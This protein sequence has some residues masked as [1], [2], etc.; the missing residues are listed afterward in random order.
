MIHATHDKSK[1]E[2]A[3]KITVLIAVI[4]MIVS[5]C[6][7]SQGP[8]S[9][10]IPTATPTVFMPTIIA[11]MTPTPDIGD[12]AGAFA[13]CEAWVKSALDN[14]DTA[15]VQEAQTLYDKGYIPPR[16]VSAGEVIYQ[17]DSG[18]EEYGPQ[19]DC[20][21]E[22]V[23]NGQYLPWDIS[24]G[25]ISIYHRSPVETATPTARVIAPTATHKPT[26][27]RDIE[28]EIIHGA[29]DNCHLYT[30][31]Y[32]QKMGAV[33]PVEYPSEFTSVRNVE[34]DGLNV[35]DVAVYEDSSGTELSKSWSCTV[36]YQINSTGIA[37]TLDNLVI[38]ELTV[39][40]LTVTLILRNHSRFLFV[41]ATRR[42]FYS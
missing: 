9:T 41:S 36:S 25:E 4:T 10:E 3:M 16:W 40:P 11:K 26:A 22:Y 28:S 39:F 18:P 21:L 33:I 23:G 17:S 19:W 24:L 38:D 14:P 20:S 30:E 15:K 2:N 34:G 5:A 27:I 37:Y 7:P 1:K 31:Y 42:H 8:T 13:V 32:L 29:I 6:T 12:V 35:E